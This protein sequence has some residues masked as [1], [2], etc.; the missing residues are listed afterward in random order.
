MRASGK[1]SSFALLSVVTVKDEFGE[2]DEEFRAIDIPV[3]ECEAYSFSGI[4][5]IYEGLSPLMR[6]VADACIEA[7]FIGK[8]HWVKGSEWSK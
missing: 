4:D 5:D 6:S 8:G 3:K 1:Q 2:S 7:I